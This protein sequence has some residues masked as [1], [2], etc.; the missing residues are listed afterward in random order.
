M[1]NLFSKFLSLE[2]LIFQFA[3]L[4]RNYLF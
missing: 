3:S 2:T 4:K 1:I